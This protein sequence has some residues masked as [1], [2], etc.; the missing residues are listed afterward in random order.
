MLPDVQKSMDEQAAN[1]SAAKVGGGGAP[2]W[3][4]PALLQQIATDPLLRKAFTDPK[5]GAMLKTAAER[6]RPVRPPARHASARSRQGG[7]HPR[8]KR[9]IGKYV[10]AGRPNLPCFPH[11]C[12]AAMAALQQDPKKAMETYADV[13]EMRPYTVQPH[14]A[15]CNPLPPR[16]TCATP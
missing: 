13:P 8:P 2:E 14:A 4:T 12:G 15:P 7:L 6:F 11:R 9:P 10:P 16:P 1:S 5:R 3:V